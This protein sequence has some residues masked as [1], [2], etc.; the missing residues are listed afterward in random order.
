VTGV[1]LVRFQPPPVD[2]GFPLTAFLEHARAIVDA[3]HDRLFRA[4]GIGRLLE[5]SVRAGS[6]GEALA[7][8]IRDER[9]RRLIVMGS[10]AVPRLRAGDARRLVVAALSDDRRALTNNRFSSDVCAVSDARPLLDLPPLPGD[11]AVPRWLEEVAGFAVAELGNRDRLAFDLD[12]PLDVALLVAGTPRPPAGLAALVR[13]HDL[14]VPRLAEL[15]AAALD[16]RRELLVFGRSGSRTLAWLEANV[17]CRVRFLAEE[18]GLRASTPLAFGPDGGGER[19]GA[20]AI[21]GTSSARRHPRA[22]L[23]RLLEREGPAALA[24]IVADLGDA[25]II[26]TRVLLAD[27]LGVDESAWPRP[28]DRFASDLLRPDVIRD[29]W[30]RALTESAAFSPVPILPGAH[31]LVGPGVRLLLG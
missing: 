17:P 14:A 7:D 8:L 11:N 28:E 10:G 27:R 5:V 2:G 15:R 18:R 20:T 16:P 4:A 24:S 29:P 9:L 13:S 23:G 31:T 6:W 19:G 12:S 21:V 1:V 25:A 30:L 3:H 26:D 22:T